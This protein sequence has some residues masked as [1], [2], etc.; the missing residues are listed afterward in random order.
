MDVYEALYTT[1]AMRR[2]KPDPIPEDVQQRILDAAIRAPTGGDAQAW[3]FLVVDDPEVKAR[4]G[5]VYRECLGQLWETIYKPQADAAAA[6]PEAPESRKFVKMQS[7]AQHLA[8]HFE[9]VPLFFVAFSQLD[10]TGSSIFPAVWSAMLAAR[11]EGVGSALTS[12]MLFQLDRM[13]EVLGAPRD[14]GWN[15]NACVAMGYP[16]GRWGIAPRKPVHEVA[17]RNQWDQPLGFEID[18]PLWTPGS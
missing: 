14:S 16:L 3:R 10:T 17:N 15:F 8:D 4:L 11:A 13:L 7:S 6:N 5:A 2:M 12:V 1:R 9:E 18:A